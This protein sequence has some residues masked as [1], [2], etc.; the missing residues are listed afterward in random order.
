MA[1]ASHVGDATYC[2]PYMPPKTRHE[3]LVPQP[4]LALCEL[5]RSRDL[6]TFSAKHRPSEAV[7]TCLG[8]E[9]DVAADELNLPGRQYD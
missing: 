1:G 2:I 9:R 7:R 6:L 3:P 5:W 4:H 8:Q